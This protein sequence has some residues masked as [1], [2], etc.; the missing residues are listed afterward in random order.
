MFYFEAHRAKVM[1]LKSLHARAAAVLHQAR[2][3]VP[4]PLSASSS[5]LGF[6]R[7]MERN[8]AAGSRKSR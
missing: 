3:L 7:G 5:V 8:R 1:K 6:P 2:T 4:L